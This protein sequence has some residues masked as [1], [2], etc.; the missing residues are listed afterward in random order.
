MQVRAVRNVESVALGLLTD[1]IGSH[2]VVFGRV[3]NAPART[4]ERLAAWFE[5]I[6][7]TRSPDR[8]REIWR[9]FAGVPGGPNDAGL[10]RSREGKAGSLGGY[11]AR[12]PHGAGRDRCTYLQ[13]GGLYRVLLRGRRPARK[14]ELVQ[15]LK[16]DRSVEQGVERT[17][18]EDF[19][20][21]PLQ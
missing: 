2:G 4:L 11:A 1:R 7:V 20:A 9:C 10:S 19:L 21:D 6:R 18:Q 12:A 3:S 15:L 13:R 16:A 8:S 14:R 17:P 5:G